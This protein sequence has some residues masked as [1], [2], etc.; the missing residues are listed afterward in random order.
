MRF[1]DL[2]KAAVC[3]SS[4]AVIAIALLYVYAVPLAGTPMWAAMA[5]SILGWAVSVPFGFLFQRAPATA[6]R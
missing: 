2:L 6:T 3:L 5:A 4:A 1:R